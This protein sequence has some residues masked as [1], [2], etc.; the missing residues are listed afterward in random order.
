M[1][2]SVPLGFFAGRFQKEARRRSALPAWDPCRG[3]DLPIR[4]RARSR[5]GGPSAIENVLRY[6]PPNRGRASKPA[7][8]IG[9]TRN[10][11]RRGSPPMAHPRCPSHDYGVACQARTKLSAAPPWGWTERPVSGSES[12]KRAVEI[13]YPRSQWRMGGNPSVGRKSSARS[14][15]AWSPT[16]GTWETRSPPLDS[17]Y[18]AFSKRSE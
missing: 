8:L 16:L 17:R 12:K 13:D 5:F 6:S 4:Q 10:R 15:R 9:L 1:V 7:P 2:H 11:H 14:R 18:L 3:A